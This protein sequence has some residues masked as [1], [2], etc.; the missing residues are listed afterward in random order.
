MRSIPRVVTRLARALSHGMLMAGMANC[1]KHF[2]GH[3]YAAADSHVALPIDDREVSRI[4]HAD[5]KTLY[6]DGHRA[7]F[8]HDG[9]RGVSG[10]R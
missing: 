8:R 1:G 4:E 6:L 7:G 5:V 9:A 2:P 10:L 3:G